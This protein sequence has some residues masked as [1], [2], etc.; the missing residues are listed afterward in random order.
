MGW[1]RVLRCHPSELP[2]LVDD[3]P[4][5]ECLIKVTQQMGSR[6]CSG[7]KEEAARL[8]S[9][10]RSPLSLLMFTQGPRC[11]PLSHLWVPLTHEKV[12][13]EGIL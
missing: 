4:G 5:E 10:H 9:C 6:A 1:G 3:Q 7:P 2:P 13:G 12:Q 8:C 11:R